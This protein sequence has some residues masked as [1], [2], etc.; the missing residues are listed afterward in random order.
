MAWR[1]TLHTPSHSAWSGHLEHRAQVHKLWKQILGPSLLLAS[2]SP[3]LWNSQ[4]ARGRGKAVGRMQWVASG[5]LSTLHIHFTLEK[6]FCSSCREWQLSP[7]SRLQPGPAG[8][9]PK[10]KGSKAL[11][12]GKKQP[13]PRRTQWPGPWRT[14]SGRGQSKG[15]AGHSLMRA[16]R[17]YTRTH[18]CKLPG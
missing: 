8:Q 13:A 17:V 12:R 11:A 3:C 10:I 4:H 2:S 16:Y 7:P 6:C 9:L 5:I 15:I 1:R 18:T 14:F